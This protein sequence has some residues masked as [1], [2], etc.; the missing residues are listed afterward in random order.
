MTYASFNDIRK[1]IQNCIDE[2]SE[3][4]LV[5]VAWFTSK[6]IIGQLVNKLDNSCN[7]EIVVSDH[8]ENKKVNYQKFIDKGGRV[9]IL[10]SS[11]DRFLHEKYALFDCKKVVAGS[12][13]WT[14]SAEFYNHE[15]VIISEDKQLVKQFQ[16]RFDK[17]KSK[18]TKYDS[19]RF[20]LSNIVHAETKEDEFLKIEDNLNKDFIQS[21]DEALR[22]GAKIDKSIILNMIYE[23]GALGA[24]S[25]LVNEGT[26][27]LHSGLLKLFEVNR[28]DL[29][30]E[31]IIL[32]EQY[33]MLFSN[34]ILLKAEKRL[35]ALNKGH[36]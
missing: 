33:R 10:N 14:N 1:K 36:L 34:E 8:Y 15:F 6:D 18:A 30:I 35:Q 2:A 9:Y 19:S 23:Y 24:A 20:K 32:K 5:S 31:A 21:I 26:D 12:Y 7:V 22:A 13:N 16:I 25:R 17:I 28:L 3:S 11:G 29:T 27:K 4:I